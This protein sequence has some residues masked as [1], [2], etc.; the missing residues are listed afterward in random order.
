MLSL[1]CDLFVHSKIKL[2]PF[3]ERNHI[4]IVE[5]V[6]WM[7][8]SLTEEVIRIFRKEVISYQKTKIDSV[9]QK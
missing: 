5:L 6:F 2:I 4:C 9:I 3:I 7:I 1:T 8:R